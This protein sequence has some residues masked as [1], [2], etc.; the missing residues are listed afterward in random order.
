MCLY[1]F[2]RKKLNIASFL[3]VPDLLFECINQWE[4]NANMCDLFIFSSKNS[5]FVALC[6][7][8]LQNKQMLNCSVTDGEQ[9]LINIWLELGRHYDNVKEL[10]KL[11]LY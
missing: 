8:K 1:S 6:L 4:C 7:F 5:C 11:V 10:C 3:C 2:S 9:E